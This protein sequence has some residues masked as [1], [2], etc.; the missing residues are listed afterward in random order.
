MSISWVSCWVEVQLFSIMFFVYHLFSFLHLTLHDHMPTS[1]NFS[2][3]WYLGVESIIHDNIT[4]HICS[5]IGHLVARTI[6][7]IFGMLLIAH[8]NSSLSST[9]SMLA[10][11]KDASLLEVLL[12]S[13][14]LCYTI[15]FTAL[16]PL[17]AV[18]KAVYICFVEHPSSLS[19]AF[20]LIYQR[21]RRISDAR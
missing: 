7:L 17:R 8:Q 14:V 4:T 2:F 12:F 21:L 16:E 3:P 19:Q 5:S 20:P 13:Y 1:S 6:T 15:I 18:I 11:N 9:L 10:T